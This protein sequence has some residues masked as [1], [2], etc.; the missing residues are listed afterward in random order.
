MMICPHDAPW[1]SNLRFLHLMQRTIGVLPVPCDE[2]PAGQ[3]PAY[4][5]VDSLL[6]DGKHIRAGR[7]R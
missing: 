6:L 5:A 3:D 1:K 7:R 2:L 4:E